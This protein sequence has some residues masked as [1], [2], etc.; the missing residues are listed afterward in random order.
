M[1]I[2]ELPSL[3]VFKTLGK[4]N[5]RDV[6]KIGKSNKSS[7]YLKLKTYLGSNR[8]SKILVASHVNNANE[9]QDIILKNM[10]NEPKFK[11]SSKLG[12]REYFYCNDENYLHNYI[13]DQIKEYNMKHNTYLDL[14]SDSDN[15]SYNSDNE[16]INIHTTEKDDIDEKNEKYEN[17]EKDNYNVNLE[18]YEKEEKYENNDKDNNNV[19]LEKINSSQKMKKSKKTYD[20]R[21]PTRFILNNNKYDLPEDYSFIGLLKV[22]IKETF[23]SSNLSIV[24][25]ENKLIQNACKIHNKNLFVRYSEDAHKLD[26]IGSKLLLNLERANICDV[27]S[28]SSNITQLF[29]IKLEFIYDNSDQLV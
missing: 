8:P 21:M 26:I 2:H 6:Y 16:N 12:S 11:F 19:N 15:D 28:I 5:N 4:V 14:D 20:L 17:N 24:D 7:P 9:L 18:N 3:Y 10:S 22:L 23:V 25:F 27:K 29:N 13:H 1:S